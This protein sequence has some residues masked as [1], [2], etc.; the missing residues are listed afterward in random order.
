MKQ[1]KR[2]DDF[3]SYRYGHFSQPDMEGGTI[4]RSFLHVYFCYVGNLRYQFQAGLGDVI[5]APIY[6]VL[7]ERGV[8]FRFFHKVEEL[9]LHHTDES[10]VEEIRITKQV[11]T[12]DYNYNPLIT[13]KNLPCWPN[14]PNYEQIVDDEAQ[15]LQEQKIDLDSFRTK[16]PLIYEEHFNQQ[17]PEINLRRGQDFDIVVHGIS[18]ASLPLI[19]PQLL[20]ASP[21]SEICT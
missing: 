12:I 15:L 4:L 21:Q 9:I 20:E 16:L 14:E 6:Q 7:K 3:I 18:I 11:N 8:K 1:V 5:F 19:S 2:H 10:L 17:L 13:V